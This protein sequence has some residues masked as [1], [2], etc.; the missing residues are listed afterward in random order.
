MSDEQLMQA[1]EELD[2]T[3]LLRFLEEMLT[4]K[5]GAKLGISLQVFTFGEGG[6]MR[7]GSNAPRDAM[8]QVLRELLHKWERDRVDPPRSRN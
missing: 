2:L 8:E 7:Y 6:A 3:P 5:T 4:L 1:V